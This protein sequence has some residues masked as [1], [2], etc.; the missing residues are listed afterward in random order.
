MNMSISLDNSHVFER[1][2]TQA[3]KLF[4]SEV[5]LKDEQLDELKKMTGDFIDKQTGKTFYELGKLI[6]EINLDTDNNTIDLE[7]FKFAKHKFMKSLGFQRSIMDY[8][9][10]KKYVAVIKPSS[11][12]SM[13]AKIILYYKPEKPTFLSTLISS[14]NENELTINTDD[15]N[16][17]NTYT[18]DD[19]DTHIGSDVEQLTEFDSDTD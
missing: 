13:I 19:V 10:K 11:P 4:L 17:S 8:Y 15:L 3:F 18:F 7:K 14:V 6:I 9:Q 12:Q 2:Y 16:K 5:C 1:L